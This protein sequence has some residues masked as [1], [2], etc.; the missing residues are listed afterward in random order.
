MHVHM[1]GVHYLPLALYFTH[2]W[3]DGARGRDAV[4]AVVFLVLQGAASF[5]LAYA[6]M[7]A[8]GTAVLVWVVFHRAELD[9]RRWIGLAGIIGAIG[10]GTLATAWPYLQLQAAG[11]I[12]SFEDPTLSPIGLR[13]AVTRGQ[14]VGY[15]KYGGVG[16]VGYGLAAVG[17]CV[18]DGVIGEVLAAVVR[19]VG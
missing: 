6:Q 4:L 15:L 19:S 13:P 11:V 7:V 10:L 2:R 9:R 12:P 18:L 8:Y 3:L 14:V 17:E 5:Y 1:M 16:W